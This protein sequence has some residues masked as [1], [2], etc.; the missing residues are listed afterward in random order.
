ME[1]EIGFQRAQAI[2]AQ[3]DLDATQAQLDAI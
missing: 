3:E 1:N 2:R